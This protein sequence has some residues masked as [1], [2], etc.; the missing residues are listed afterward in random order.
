MFRSTKEVAL[1]LGVKVGT[2]AASVWAGR[3][4]E[5][6][7]S[8][9]GHFLWTEHDISRACRVMRGRLLA[10]VLAERDVDQRQGGRDER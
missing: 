3:I 2:L 9:A 5:P 1:M 6:D 10:D 4:P 8:P 7:R